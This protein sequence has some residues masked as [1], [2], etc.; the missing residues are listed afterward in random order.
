MHHIYW[1]IINSP[2]CHCIF[3]HDF[4]KIII[5]PLFNQQNIIHKDE[6]NTD[7]AHKSCF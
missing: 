5:H 2:A 3:L 6:W 7:K 4:E 1:C